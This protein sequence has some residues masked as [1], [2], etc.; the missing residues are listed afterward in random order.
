MGVSPTYWKEL[1]LAPNLIKGI[2]S[3]EWEE[4]IQTVTETFLGLTV[5]CARCHDHKFDPISQQDYYALAGVFA[6]SQPGDFPLKIPGEPRVPA[7]IESALVLGPGERQGTKFELKPGMVQDVAVQ[8]HGNPAKCGPVV[9]RRFLSVLSPDPPPPFRQGSGR[10]ELAQALVHEGRALAARV[11]VNRIWQ[12]HFGTGLVATAS[13]FG[14]QGARP[15]HPELLEY[16]A[17]RFV[18]SGWSV[19]RLHRDMLLSA[20]YRQASSPNSACQTIDGENRWLW[21]MNRRR[22]EV[23]VWRDAML[24]VIG[25]LSQEFGGQGNSLLDA[26]N[27]RR[28]LYGLISRQQVDDLLRLYDFPDPNRSTAG[29]FVTTTPLQQLLVLNGP[30]VR[31]SALDLVRRLA[32]EG[33]ADTLGKVRKAYMLLFGRPATE[34]ELQLA[35]DFLQGKNASEPADGLWVAME[36]VQALLAS[37]EFLYID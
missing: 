17:E 2:V 35:V 8:L 36:Y 32:R 7:M 34:A 9:P 31:Q 11:M 5:A 27:Y 37:N 25:K 26:K 23:E 10:L 29:R 20:V 6:S 22:L 24:S 30:L 12:H 4:R 14:A 33:S 15:S 28:T 16:L 3:D 18:A 19:K 13:N 21:R 1:K